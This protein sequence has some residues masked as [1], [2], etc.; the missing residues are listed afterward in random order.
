MARENLSDRVTFHGKLTEG[1]ELSS[2]KKKNRG[3]ALRPGLVR[4]VHEQQGGQGQKQ[5]RLEKDGGTGQDK[6]R[7]LC[8]DFV[9]I[10][11]SCRATRGL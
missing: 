7:G 3:K 9:L 1:K 2:Q 6:P 8:E 4:R 5:R 11:A 10:P